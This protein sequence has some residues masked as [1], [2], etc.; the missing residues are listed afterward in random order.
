VFEAMNEQVACSSR[1]LR[2]LRSPRDDCC[3]VAYLEQMAS[4]SE[5]KC[6]SSGYRLLELEGDFDAL[7]VATGLDREWY[8]NSRTRVG[9]VK[10]AISF[11]R[12]IDKPLDGL[13]SCKAEVKPHCRAQ[14]WRG[15]AVL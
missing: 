13:C 7:L 15:V 10:D 4:R 11:S 9:G 2:R 1:P 3:D 5:R 6:E 14:G 8:G 12:E